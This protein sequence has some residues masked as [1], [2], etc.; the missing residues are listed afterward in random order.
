MAAL[1]GELILVTGDHDMAG[2]ARA[3]GLP[4]ALTSSQ[5]ALGPEVHAT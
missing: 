2:A 1:D 4:V 3:Q 5:P